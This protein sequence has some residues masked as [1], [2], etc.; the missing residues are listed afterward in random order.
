MLNGACYKRLVQE[1]PQAVIVRMVLEHS[2]ETEA[3]DQ[4]FEESRE[5]STREPYCSRRSCN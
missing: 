2:L 3:V 4:V 1:A 5:D